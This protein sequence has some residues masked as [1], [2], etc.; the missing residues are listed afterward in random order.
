M[1]FQERK[2]MSGA[3]MYNLN[4]HVSTGGGGIAGA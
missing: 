4:R 2:M 3:S 1:V